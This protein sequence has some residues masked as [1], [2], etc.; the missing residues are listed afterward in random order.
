MKFI[1][2]DGEQ[3]ND[4][5]D[6]HKL[7]AELLGFPAWYGYNLDALYDCLSDTGETACIYIKNGALLRSK[8]GARG[9]SLFSL[10]RRVANER[11]NIGCY[12][13]Y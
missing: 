8:L 11:D 4:I 5:S 6:I 9:E 12:I 13:D 1:L 3:I 10:L 7:F 2:I